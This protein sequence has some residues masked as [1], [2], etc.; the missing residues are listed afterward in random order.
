MTKPPA[1]QIYLIRSLLMKKYRK[2]FI[3]ILISAVLIAAILLLLH[4]MLY[5]V[6]PSQALTEP[7]E[8]DTVFN[9]IYSSGDYS[10]A[11][12]A[13]L[14]TK[15]G[16]PT[17]AMITNGKIY[18]GIDSVGSFYNI[19]FDTK[20][21]IG[22]FT[23][24]EFNKTVEKVKELKDSSENAFFYIYCSAE[25]VLQCLAIAANARIPVE[26]FH[27]YM[28]ENRRGADTALLENY[29]KGKTMTPQVD[30][31][32]DN[33]INTVNEAKEKFSDIMKRSRNKISSLPKDSAIP[34]ALASFGNFTYHFTDSEPIRI[35]LDE[36]TF[37]RSKLRYALKLGQ[38]DEDPV[39]TVNVEYKSIYDI[40][41]GRIDE[42]TLN[43]YRTL[44]FGDVLLNEQTDLFREKCNG[45]R[46][47]LTK[48]IF[49]GL[50]LSE[51]PKYA[52]DPEH[53][54]G[55]LGANDTIPST[56]AGLDD[57]YKFELL[58]ATEEDYKVFFDVV[59]DNSNYPEGI[60]SEGREKIKVA[61]FNYYIDYM[62][63]LKFVDYHYDEDVFINSNIAERLG[64]YE[65]WGGRYKITVDGKEYIYDKLVDTVLS[66]FHSS[67]SVGKKIGIFENYDNIENIAYTD[68]KFNIGGL[69]DSDLA[70]IYMSM[71]ELNAIKFV[72]Y[73]S[74]E[75]I[76]TVAPDF[77]EWLVFDGRYKEDETYIY[78]KPNTYKFVSKALSEL[79]NKEKASEYEYK[80][81][82]WLLEEYGERVPEIVNDLQPLGGSSSS[83]ENKKAW[84][85]KYG[86]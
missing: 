54:I 65:D 53:G 40:F 81:D 83:Y 86:K 26:D 72:L 44:L 19:G 25:D 60:T 43:S 66:A 33:Y 42:D 50:P 7:S 84:Y 16:Y 80:F 24:E 32:Y 62:F 6:Y 70:N 56:Y 21:N 39:N 2:L 20:N 48:L 67:D 57:K 37:I 51:Y 61:L 4:T 28:C 8:G 47:M 35:V 74:D 18:K 58:F 68:I 12:S 49:F 76:H 3:I 30:G 13:A 78:N 36:N 29:V 75:L 52:S 22:E 73:E 41:L 79:K 77:R 63:A 59:N 10:S 71:D 31:V 14:S 11:L 27:I 38:S 1:Q 82:M 46:V 9:I 34:F 5:K 64:A 15:N 55:G 69:I 17:Y 85:D 45:K 23:K